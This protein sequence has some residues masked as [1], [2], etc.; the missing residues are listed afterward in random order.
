MRMRKKKNLS[1]RLENV[2]EYIVLHES[3]T[4]FRLPEEERYNYLDLE[5]VF[6]NNNPLYLEIGCGKGT[7]ITE[8]AIKNPNCNYIGVE[9]LENVIV[10]AGEMAQRKNLSNV[11]F[12]NMGAE[13]LQFFLIRR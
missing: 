9:I 6:G 8:T 13:L 10:M 3:T 11:K 1:S 7:F 12:F 5:T 2:N 4:R